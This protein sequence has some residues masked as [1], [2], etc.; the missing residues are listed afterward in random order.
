VETVTIVGGGLAGMVA[1]LRLAERGCDVS[2]YEASDRLGGKAGATRNGDRYDEHGFHIFPAWYLNVWRLVD[3]LNIRDNFV[4]MEDFLELLPGQFP[5]MTS[6]H[7]V[8]S[9][10]SVPG[11]ILSGPMTPVQ[12]FLFLY[13]ILDLV[14]QHYRERSFLDQ[15]TSSG[16]IRSRFYRTE[17]I[18]KEQQDLMLKGI[19]VPLYAVSAMTVHK[20][21]AFWLRYPVPQCRILRGNLQEYWIAPLERRLRDLGVKIFFSTRLEG[22]DFTE[23]RLT[24]LRLFGDGGSREQPVEQVI[25]AIPVEKLCPLIDDDVFRVAP[26]LGN[27]R[28]I[29]TQPMAALNIEFK[30]TIPGIPR[31]HVN[32]PGS[33]F[34]LTFIDVSQTW[35]EVSRNT[36]LNVVASDFTPLETISDD[37][38]IGLMFNELCRFIPGIEW[39]DV[40]RTYFQPHLSEP[41]F[42]NEAGVWAFRPKART[43]IPNLVLAGD[44]CRTHVDLVSM[45]GAVTSGLHAADAVGTTL[46]LEQPVCIE[47][48]EEVPRWLLVLGKLALLPVATIAKLWIMIRSE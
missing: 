39:S 24:H 35:T 16:F 20:V 21:A 18:A 7:N 8:G 6:L 33:R 47:E 9:V 14:S 25:V 4:E 48:P 12:M 44:Y 42:M 32:L 3:E 23:S 41:L 38:A 31:S 15:I 2:L 37:E 10:A 30:R 29:H 1:A 27:L 28:Y 43:E 36:L 45:E 22:F 5:K 17:E 40:E 13:S 26:S 34:G 46:G 19:S 11:N